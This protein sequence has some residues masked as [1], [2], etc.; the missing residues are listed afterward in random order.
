V[1][2]PAAE[3]AP[4]ALLVAFAAPLVA[5]VFAAGLLPALVVVAFAAIE[6]VAVVLA[7]L[8][9]LALNTP[10]PALGAPAEG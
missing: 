7:A 10:P 5:V 2:L 9:L 1:A 6:V 4:D 8:V 3:V